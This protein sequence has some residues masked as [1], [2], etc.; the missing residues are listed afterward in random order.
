MAEKW[1]AIDDD[2]V[3]LITHG[4]SYGILDRAPRGMLDFEHV[5]CEELRKVIDTR[6]KQLKLHAHGHIHSDSNIIRHNDMIIVNAAIC[7][8]Q[9][10]PTNPVRIIE[11]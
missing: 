5:G 8:E 7:D 9:Y 2:V 6:L 4:P 3:C 10:K 1:A 11:I